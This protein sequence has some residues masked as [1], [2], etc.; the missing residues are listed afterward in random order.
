MLRLT[1]TLSGAT[2]HRHLRTCLRS[3]KSSPRSAFVS[4]IGD[5][6]RPCR[7]LRHALPLSLDGNTLLR[8]GGVPSDTRSRHKRLD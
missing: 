4:V 5:S 2:E 7:A 8:S 1:Q 3:R 6:R